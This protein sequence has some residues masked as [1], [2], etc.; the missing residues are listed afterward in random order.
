MCYVGG[1]NEYDRMTQ[2]A[3]IPRAPEAQD[4]L[5]N[6]I[7][8]TKKMQDIDESAVIEDDETIELLLG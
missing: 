7:L 8:S 3:G 5:P 1:P 4:F 6:D 2:K